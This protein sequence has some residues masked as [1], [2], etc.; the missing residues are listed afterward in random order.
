MLAQK[1]RELKNGQS[2]M[3]AVKK[4]ILRLR[5]ALEQQYDV[6]TMTELEND[7]RNKET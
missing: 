3:L 2:R 1:E 6:A 4:D 5:Q 7:I